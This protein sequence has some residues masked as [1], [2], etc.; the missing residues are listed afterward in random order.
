[1]AQQMG[2]LRTMMDHLSTAARPVPVSAS[3]SDFN[4]RAPSE[5]ILSDSQLA[6]F[7]ADG[8]LNSGAALLSPTEVAELSDVLDEIIERGPHGWG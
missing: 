7:D 3:T 8:F 1:M 5:H 2:R 6:Q 4:P